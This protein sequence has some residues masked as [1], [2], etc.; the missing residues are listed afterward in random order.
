[1]SIKIIAENRKARHDYHIL[2][3]IE[4]GLVLLG[5]E[6]KSLRVSGC[7]IKESYVSVVGH[8]L[9]LQKAHI[10]P[11]LSSSYNNHEPERLRKLLLKQNQIQKVMTA[12]SEK[13]LSCVPL[14]VYFS[15]G[16]V[17]VEIAIVRGKKHHDK[18]EAIK[19]RD[20]QKQLQRTVRKS[21]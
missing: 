16:F 18:R 12:L 1:V 11:Y 6:V 8:E 3:V 9:F 21:K 20:T 4:A 5:S 19:A 13:G 14:K 17:K 10:P 15:K 2:E 7:S